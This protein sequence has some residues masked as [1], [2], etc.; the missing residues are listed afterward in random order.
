MK[1]M[2]LA[3]VLALLVAVADAE[4]VVRKSIANGPMYPETRE[5]TLAAM[6]RFYEG[7]K[8]SPPNQKLIASIVPHS[9]WGFCGPIIAA[10]LKELEIGQYERVIVLAPSHA[11]GFEGC[12]MPAVQGFSLPIG[13]IPLDG[14]VMGKL[15]YS[16]LISLRGISYA[17]KRR[18]PALHETEHSIEVVAPFLLER[19]GP[20]Y[21]VPILVGDLKELD[22]KL[23]VPRIESVAESLREVIDDKTLLV[24]STDFTHFGNDFSFRPFSQ[25]IPENIEKLD[26]DAFN[27]LI[28]K[29]FDG[30]LRYLEDTHN[31]ICGQAALLI[32]LKLLPP[33]ARGELIDYTQSQYK[34][35]QPNRSVS[36]AAI[37]FYDTT[38][39]PRPSV[40]QVAPL[41]KGINPGD[42]DAPP[43]V[44]TTPLPQAAPAQP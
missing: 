38:L 14:A 17:D 11:A 8:Y 27:L 44:E 24:V 18:R 42:N 21:L 31:P 35:K 30:F 23:S 29:D 28:D 40:R 33:S 7:V 26:R 43:A 3:C 32:L 5:A 37:N 34:T 15:N 39:P 6:Q 10:G 9:A 2:L 20:F 16:A 13:L 1:R 4:T 22:G 36:Y 25:N 12:S 41:V 19:L